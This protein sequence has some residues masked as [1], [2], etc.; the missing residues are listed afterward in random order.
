MLYMA[1]AANWVVVGVERVEAGRSRRT[2]AL[3][4][5]A[6]NLGLM[7]LP[8]VISILALAGVLE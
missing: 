1:L 3:A 2:L 4:L 7:L 6:G 5:L 8:V